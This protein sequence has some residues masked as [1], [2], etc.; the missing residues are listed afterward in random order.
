MVKPVLHRKHLMFNNKRSILGWREWAGLP[1]L[2]IPLLK[3]KIDTGARSSALHTFALENFK[4]EGRDWV[5]FQ[6]H[7]LQNREDIALSAEAPVLDQRLV[8]DSGGH[9]EYR[10][11]IQTHINIMNQSFLSEISLTT[12]DTMRFRMLIGRT[13][14][15]GRFMVDPEQSY[16]AGEHSKSSIV[17]LYRR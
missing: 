14:L 7:P 12:R 16:L 15:N 8:T 3:A 2:G 10:Y 1:D 9:Q 11:F 13:A 6:L 4:K 17:K 5:R